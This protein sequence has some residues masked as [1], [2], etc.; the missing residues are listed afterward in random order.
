M[1]FVGIYYGDP[2]TDGGWANFKSWIGTYYG[3]TVA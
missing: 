1:T 2:E 3:I